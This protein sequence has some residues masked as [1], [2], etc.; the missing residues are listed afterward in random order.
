LRGAGDL[1]GTKQSGSGIEALMEEMT[2][3][4]VEMAQHEARAIH[5]EDPDL[6]Q[7]EHRLLAQ[8]VLML[9]DARSDVS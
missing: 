5:A 4:L 6:Q 1:I 7:P 8:R 2:P 9:R 3:D